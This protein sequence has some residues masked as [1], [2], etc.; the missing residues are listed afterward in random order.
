MS[1]RTALITGASGGLGAEFARIHASRGGDLVLVARSEPKLNQLKVELE[2]QFGVN[3]LVIAQDLAEPHAAQDIIRQIDAAGIEI[4]YLINNAGFGLGG[5]FADQDLARISN[6]IQVNILALTQLTHLLL[7]RLRQL[8]AGKILNVSS[9][10][11]LM[12]G[13]LQAVYFATKAYVTSFSNA[14]A[15]ELKGSGVTVTVLLPGPVDTGFAS[16]AEMEDTPL[17]AN[18][19]PPHAVA[20][21]GYEGMLRGELNV[22]AGL[23]FVQRSLLKLLPLVPRSLVMKYTERLQR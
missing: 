9:I 2:S 15:H 6:M 13:P 12:P 1:T 7:P 11:S 16:A 19:V 17:F 18:G 4:D 8:Q 14:L 22:I 23:P 3:A 10:A 20:L 5:E 21:T